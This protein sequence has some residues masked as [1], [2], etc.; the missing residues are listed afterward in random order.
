MKRTARRIAGLLLLLVFPLSGI[1]DE[2]SSLVTLVPQK[3]SALSFDQVE[4]ILGLELLS[5]EAGP[6]N[7]TAK[8]L[9]VTVSCRPGLVSLSA[10]KSTTEPF[11]SRLIRVDEHPRDGIERVIAIAVAELALSGWEQTASDTIQEPDSSK[12]TETGA[13]RPAS[14]ETT[15]SSKRGQPKGDRESAH[16]ARGKERLDAAVQLG[17]LWR[18]FVGSKANL[19]GGEIGGILS[20]PR[21]F[22]MRLLVTP[23]GGRIERAIGEVS[24]FSVSGAYAFGLEG[25]L[26]SAPLRGGVD[27]G[28]RGGYAQLRGRATLP[29]SHGE[30]MSGGFGGPFLS[31]SL[32]SAT[33]PAVGLSMEAG[34]ALIGVAGRIE[35]ESPIEINGPWLSVSVDC[36]LYTRR[37]TGR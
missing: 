19:F 20:F 37:K 28:F 23:E 1:A 22:R 2:F 27:V 17:A 6:R 26:F 11:T 35:G 14:P 7:L 12:R 21:L 30:T 32:A 34:W 18:M 16:D 31:L 10:R 9:V 29:I 5:I 36:L 8:P 25:R 3:C 24:S 33:R 15:D 4:R 13:P